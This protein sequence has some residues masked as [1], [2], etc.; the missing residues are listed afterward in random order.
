[1]KI[2]SMRVLLTGAGG[3]IGSAIAQ[4]LAAQGAALLLAG[5]TPGPLHA[6]ARD[7]AARGAQVGVE[8]AD[9]TDVADRERLAE[10][11]RAF[12]INVLVQAAG[13]P[14][15]GSFEHQGDALVASVLLTNLVAPMQLAQRLLP[16]LRRKL[17]ARVLNIGSALGR[18]ALPG[19]AIYS[20][21]KFGLRGFSEA[22]RRELADSS[23]RVQYLGPRSTQTS[24]ND[25]RVEAYNRATGS[26]SDAPDR[27][28]RA[29]VQL[30]ESG[31]AERFIGFPERLAVR[32]NGLVPSLLD[33]AFTNHG[34][35]LRAVN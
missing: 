20:A 25:R 24:F 13:A 9:V 30:L 27:V 22:L 21:S 17:Q 19:Y 28:A 16:Q 5:R 34:A 11:A 26:R 35:A 12:D 6:L 7:L 15:F 8:A 3:G 14:A 2:A 32:L 4:D 10:A 23:V 29:A 31:A 33:G 18:L 1:M